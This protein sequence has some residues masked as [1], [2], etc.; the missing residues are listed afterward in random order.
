LRVSRK[1]RG[2]T[3]TSLM[4]EPPSASRFARAVYR[5]AA[6]AST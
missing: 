1:D 5:A 3:V 2:S 4:L 6:E